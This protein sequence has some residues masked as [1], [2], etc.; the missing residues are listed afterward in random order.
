MRHYLKLSVLNGREQCRKF[1]ALSSSLSTARNII[2]IKEREIL[3]T[4]NQKR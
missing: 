4:K 1:E 2:I 3:E